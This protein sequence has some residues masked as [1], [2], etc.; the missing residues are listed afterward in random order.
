[1]STKLKTL[2][3][4]IVSSTLAACGGGGGGDYNVMPSPNDP[5]QVVPN[6]PNVGGDNNDP[7]PDPVFQT[8]REKI[9]ADHWHDQGFTGQGVTVAVLDS[10]TEDG[11]QKPGGQE[12][13]DVSM[14]ENVMASYDYNKNWN[15]N[16]DDGYTLNTATHTVDGTHGHEMA[17]VIGS[18]KDGDGVAPD[19]TLIHGVISENGYANAASMWNGL[20]WAN[21]NGATVAN[22]SF[23][24][25]GLYLANHDEADSAVESNPYAYKHDITNRNIRDEIVASGMAIIHSTENAPTNISDNVFNQDG[26]SDI[27]YTDLKDNL[28]LVGALNESQTDKASWSAYPGDNTVVSNRWI[29]APGYAN[30][31]TP[32]GYDGYVSGTSPAAAYVSGAVA[33]IKSRWNHLTGAQIT[34][35]IIATADK[36]LTDYDPSVHGQ[37]KIDMEAA[38]APYGSTS[39]QTANN[40]SVPVHAASLTLPQGFKAQS[41]T[42]SIVDSMERDYEVNVTA[43][44]KDYVSD[45]Q[46]KLMLSQQGSAE[47]EIGHV[48]GAVLKASNNYSGYEEQSVI[49]MDGFT[50]GMF[51]GTR[52]MQQV[53]VENGDVSVSLATNLEEQVNNSNAL[54]G[55]GYVASIQYGNFNASAFTANEDASYSFY[56]AKDR[57]ASG[58]QAGYDAGAV[59]LSVEMSANAIGGDSL[60]SGMKTKTHAVSLGVDLA[61][62]KDMTFGVVGKYSVSDLNVD[63]T[64]PKSNGDGTLRFE[65]ES[66]ASSQDNFGSGIYAKSG[67]VE[68]SAYSDK[69]DSNIAMTYQKKF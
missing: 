2:T 13:Y 60:V 59:A 40:V 8:N 63:M 6:D 32:D 68:L 27:L 54:K 34:D 65:N 35:H 43:E 4:A 66:M 45:F 61:S 30:V 56:G 42:T 12:N 20:K 69:N 47:T 50:K 26:F 25:G 53:K 28:L 5:Y 17:E 57:N 36:G 23:Q 24:Y 10:G 62:T 15:D 14:I 46:T 41:F 11:A 1:M 44:S 37:G 7:S 9:G 48:N 39:I 3:I 51:A 33:T 67:N 38:W 29:M 64:L 22:M 49:G 58:I 52:P 18:S 21:D 19:A 16:G 55:A 31:E